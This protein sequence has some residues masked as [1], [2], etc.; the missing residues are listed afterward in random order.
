M[1]RHIPE[2]VLE[3]IRR[4]ADLV[5]VAGSFLSVKRRGSDYWACCPFHK[6]KTPSFKINAQNQ[7]YYCFGC[8]KSGSVFTFVQE[9]VNTDFIGA[10]EWLGHRLGIAIPEAGEHDGDSGEAARRRKLREEGY[11]LLQETANRYADMLHS[12]PEAEIAR[13]YLR[14][15]GLDQEAIERFRLGYALDSW[16]DLT[17]WGQQQGYTREVLLATGLVIAKEGS[18]ER[19]YDRFR[20]RLMFPICDELGRVVGFSGRVL[21]SDPKAAKYVNSPESEFFQKGSLLYA[22]QVARHAWKRSGYAL[23]CEGQMDVIAC[24]RAGL[25][26]SVAAQGTAFTPRHAELLKRSVSRVVLAFDGDTAGSKATL[27]TIEVL[28]QA[29]LHVGVVSLPTDQDPDSIFQHGGPEALRQMMSVWEEAVP[30]VFRVSCQEHDPALPEG[31]SAIV[32]QVL[33]AIVAI[34]DSVARTAHGQWLAQQIGQ[35][36]NIVLDLLSVLLR[37]QQQ[38]AVRSAAFSAPAGLAGGGVGAVAAVSPAIL[39]PP[40]FEMPGLI[41]SDGTTVILS[42]LLDLV[43]NYDFLAQRLVQSDIHPLLPETPLGQAI[44][45][46]Q[47]LSAQGEWDLVVGEISQGALVQDSEVARCLV[48]SRFA[49]LN[50][51]QLPAGDERER[52]RNRLLRAYEDCENR[53]RLIELT[54][55]L[56]EIRNQILQDPGKVGLLA[57]YKVLLERQGHLRALCNRAS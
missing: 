38:S 3:E 29:D 56:Q 35:P 19:I 21:E 46:V 23:V 22:Q 26:F 13:S 40:P 16:D 12:R 54:R 55:T 50:P 34:R 43:L 28:H 32:Q 47:A 36:D 11:R 17:S 14:N 33:Q 25:D 41:G 1:G 31:K 10:V 8:K 9:M 6:E 37:R 20:H 2:E 7:I 49:S 5:E 4:R 52:G 27:R 51:E 24:H 53:L 48:E 18:P 15:R 44:T 57:E 45:L 42:F 39:V 30:F